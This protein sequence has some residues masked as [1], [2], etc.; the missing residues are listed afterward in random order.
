MVISCRKT[1]PFFSVLKRHISVNGILPPLQG[2]LVGVILILSLLF[3]QGCTKADD[4]K[5]KTV[6]TIGAV[7]FFLDEVQRDYHRLLSDLPESANNTQSVKEQVLNQLIDRY[8][9]LEYGQEHHISVSDDALARAVNTIRSDFGEEG[10]QEALLRDYIDFDQWKEQLRK[11]L[12]EK[13]IVQQITAAMPQPDHTEI[14]NYYETHAKAFSNK[15]QVKFR[16]IVTNNLREARDL[17]KRLGKGEDFEAL[18]RLASVAPEAKN[19]GL[20]GWVGKGELEK[21]M[22]KALFSL[23]PGQISKIIHSPY[24]YHIFQVLAS[25]PAGIKPLLEVT[26]EIE[27]ELVREKRQAFLAEWLKK[28]RKRVTVKIDENIFQ[29]LEQ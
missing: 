20:V 10:F 5:S 27:R 17:L 11:R 6:I 18:A 19:G 7:H 22:D 16:Q 13:K 28:R 21:S 9:I 26:P 25:R 14:L 8:V 2:T 15:P 29:L 4:S 3:V 12:L 24:G 1:R 23:K